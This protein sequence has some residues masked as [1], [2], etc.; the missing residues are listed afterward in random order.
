MGERHEERAAPTV[1]DL[2]DRYLS[3][4]VVAHNKASTAA[5]VRRLVETQI[6][7]QLGKL[8]ISDLR[9]AKVKAWH[10]AK[11]GIPT[12]ANRALA[13]LSKLMNATFR[14]FS[15]DQSALSAA[16]ESPANRRRM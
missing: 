6:R 3:E 13:A 14:P 1:N 11:S 16:F 9:R 5:E 10:S 8:K 4:H 7:L 12:S 2:C 15:A